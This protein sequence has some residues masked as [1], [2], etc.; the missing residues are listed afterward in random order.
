MRFANG[1]SVVVPQPGAGPETPGDYESTDQ[2]L[3]F[4]TA[5]QLSKHAGTFP[6]SMLGNAGFFKLD[7]VLNQHN[8]VSL[9]LN[10][11][12]YYGHNNVFLDPASPLTNFGISDNGQEDV[13]TETGALALTSNI[14]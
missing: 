6:S 7:L 10:T 4:A 9:R 2:A 1:S 11:S 5:A 12:R 3:A 13:S 14:S 8:N